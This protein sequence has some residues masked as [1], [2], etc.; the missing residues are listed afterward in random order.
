MPLPEQI[1]LYWDEHG[2]HVTCR[3]V[4]ELEQALRERHRECAPEHPIC[5]VVTIPGYVLCVGLGSD[6]TFIQVHVEPCDGEYYTSSGDPTETEWKDFYG[7]GGHTPFEAS[8][9]VPFEAVLSAVVEFVQY[10]RRSERL[11]WRDWAGRPV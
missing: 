5:A 9:F 4:Q 2:P 11:R 3:S 8:S 6:P 7:C 1:D 10:Q